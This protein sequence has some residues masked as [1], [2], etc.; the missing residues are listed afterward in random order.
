[1]PSP[2]AVQSKVPEPKILQSKATEPKIVQIKAAEPKILQSKAPEPI[3]IQR[4]FNGP[5]QQNGSVVEP[6]KPKLSLGQK[7]SVVAT[8]SYPQPAEEA[9]TSSVFTNG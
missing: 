6:E 2:T 8:P 7:I 4:I 1:M 9:S 3:I 5:E